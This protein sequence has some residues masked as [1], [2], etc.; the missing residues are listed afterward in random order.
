MWERYVIKIVIKE[1]RRSTDKVY[2]I[3]NVRLCEECL[4]T[5]W[6]LSSE[7]ARRRIEPSWR[8]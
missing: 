8:R 6:F 4:N 3:L 2:L 7:H 1:L 5:H